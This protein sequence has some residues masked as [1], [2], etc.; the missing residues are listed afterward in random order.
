LLLGKLSEYAEREHEQRLILERALQ[1]VFMT[2][3]RGKLISKTDKEIALWTH[4]IR[5]CDEAGLK[6]SPLRESE[7]EDH[8]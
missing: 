3:R 5:F 4:I 2:A 7:T 8:V 6:S 1:N